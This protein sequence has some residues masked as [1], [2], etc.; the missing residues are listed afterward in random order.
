MLP[1]IPREVYELY[2]GLRF[3]ERWHVRLRWRLCPF[4]QIAGHIPA[5]GRIVDIGCGRGLLANYLALT[6]P[7]RRVTGIDKQAPRIRAA[8]ASME[9]REN[10]RFLLRDALDLEREEFDVIILSDMLHHLAPPAQEQLLGHCFRVLPAGGILLLED[11]TP[12]PKWKWVV[13]FLIDRTLNLGRKQYFRALGEW[14]TLLKRIGFSVE[15]FPAHRG[16]PLPDFLLKCRKAGR[17]E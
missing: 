6:G 12:D 8:R 17:G 9:G 16:I 15:H 4:L 14:V 2:G 7:A 13:H 1:P 3:W 5:E 11:V 10:I